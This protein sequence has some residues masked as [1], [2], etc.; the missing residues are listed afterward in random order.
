MMKPMLSYCKKQL[1][2]MHAL[3]QEV[4]SER[5]REKIQKK[6]ELDAVKDEYV[7]AFSKYRSETAIEEDEDVTEKRNNGK[8]KRDPVE[9]LIDNI[10]REERPVIA[11]K[12]RVQ[13]DRPKNWETIDENYDQWGK[14]RTIKSFPDD[15]GG[16]SDRS[17]KKGFMQHLSINFFRES[18][19]AF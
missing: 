18:R 2:R 3:M 14:L 12:K 11:K 8:E 17:N 5:Y 7:L 16:H 6:K 10:C 4:E 15:F 9:E 13:L 19:C 1:K